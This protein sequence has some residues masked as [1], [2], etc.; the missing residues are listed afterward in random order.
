MFAALSFSILIAFRTRG[1]DYGV[2][3]LQLKLEHERISSIVPRYRAY[4]TSDGNQFAFRLPEGYR[5]AGDPSSGVLTLVNLQGNCSITFTIYG[6]MPESGKLDP[7]EFGNSVSNQNP[8]AT[9]TLQFWRDNGV[10]GGP[11]FDLQWK[12]TNNL[13]QCKRI[14]FLS[15]P[16]GVLAFTATADR[17]NFPTLQG[18]LDEILSSFHCTTDGTKPALPPLSD[19]S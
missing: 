8:T 18:D 14:V 4:V 9:N 10:G 17:R 7:S 3:P 19:K 2:S 12:M 11:G 16:V 15:S 1:G 6:P 5:M 13:Y